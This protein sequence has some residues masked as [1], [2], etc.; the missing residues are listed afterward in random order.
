[1][2]FDKLTERAREVLLAVHSTVHEKSSTSTK[3]KSSTKTVSPKASVNEWVLASKIFEIIQ[4]SDGVGARIIGTL[5]TIE[6][7]KTKKV[8]VERLVKEAF[9]QSLKFQHSY[10]GTEHLLLAL[11]K[12]CNSKDV[13][14]V[15]NEIL[16]QSAFP[17]GSKSTENES[18]TPLLALY[19]ENAT[20]QSYL[21]QEEYIYRD[22]LNSIIS[23][24]LQ[25]QNPNPLIVGDTGVGKDALIGFLIRRINT[26]D[27]PPKVLGYQVI[28]LDL[29]QFIAGVFNKGVNLEQSIASLLDEIRGLGRVILHIK[30]FQN[31]FIPTNS[32]LAVPLIYSLFKA[33]LTTS[34]IKI[35]ATMDFSIYDKLSTENASLISNFTVIELNEPTE[36]QTLRVMQSRAKQLEDYH[37]IKIPQSVISYAYKKAKAQDIDTK[38]PQRGIDL[39]DKACSKLIIKESKVP[40]RYKSLI[41]DTIVLAGKIDTSIEKGDYTAA[42]KHRN[43]LEKV[44]EKLSTD[45]KSMFLSKRLILTTQL[46]DV[47][48]EEDELLRSTPLPLDDLKTIQERMKKRIV[49]QDKAIEVVVKSLIRSKLGLNNKKRPVGSFLFLGPTGV[50]KTELAKVLADEAFG[51]GS[52]I[53][54]DMSDFGE[55]HTVARLVGAPPGYVGYGETGE[56]TRKIDL[57]PQSVVLFD[58][59]EKA[60]PDVLNILL[61]IME[62]GQ[63]VDAVGTAYNFN[64]AIIVLT[65]NLGTEILHRKDIGFESE[66]V[67]ELSVEARLQQNLKKSLKPELLN[68][69]DEIIVFRRLSK[70]SQNKIIGILVNDF[71][72]GLKSKRISL[73]VT[74]EVKDYLLNTGFSQE[75]GARSLRRI[76]EKELIDKVAEFLLETNYDDKQ[77]LKLE[78]FVKDGT[79]KIRNK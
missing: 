74:T 64:D 16:Q 15:R 55:K 49:G 28:S 14:K 42:L 56:L 25:K 76:V 77:N 21:S 58:E 3:T 53:R 51:Q 17:L 20:Y 36:K 32:G 4:H 65:S 72:E 23:I 5:P 33:G 69:F 45:E 73:T 71:K 57:K 54:L 24:L 35:V 63:L 59:I 52:L 34:G 30:N 70:Q 61:Q 62:E 10:V 41:D 7:S 78:A 68:R 37:N 38:F 11:L 47:A 22:E 60:H 26:L 40:D 8:E 46:I 75:F 48:L 19:G 67:N 44:E 79:I 66:L 1:M 50:G 13:E 29:I 31:I 12:V 39:L 2:S 27:V 18:R 6:F 9:F 43:A